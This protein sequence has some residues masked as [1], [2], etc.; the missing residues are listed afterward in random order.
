MNLSWAQSLVFS[1]LA[2]SL[3]TQ[4]KRE[5]R[6]FHLPRYKSK[7]PYAQLSTVALHHLTADKECYLSVDIAYCVETAGK[8]SVN[9]ETYRRL[10]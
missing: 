8:I 1:L 10:Y 5:S 2:A 3:E 9:S 4:T 7:F 6:W